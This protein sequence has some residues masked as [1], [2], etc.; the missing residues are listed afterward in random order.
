MGS[1][2]RAGGTAT[3]LTEPD[4]FTKSVEVLTL[5]LD[6]R[7]ADI[8]KLVEALVALDKRV[9]EVEGGIKRPMGSPNQ[10]VV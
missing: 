5:L 9:I 8:R 1:D 10:G 3:L 2:L 7:D 6:A 4:K